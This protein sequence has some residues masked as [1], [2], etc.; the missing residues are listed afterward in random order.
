MSPSLPCNRAPRPV[1]PRFSVSVGPANSRFS[2][3][4]R[5]STRR[6]RLP[7]PQSRPAA[8]PR[9]FASRA[10]RGGAGA[11]GFPEFP[12]GCCKI[13]RLLQLPGNS[14]FRS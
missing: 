7:P 13:R 1:V 10:G 12:A 11:G 3:A 4:P 14:R 9:S 2:S 5:P 8:P 6:S